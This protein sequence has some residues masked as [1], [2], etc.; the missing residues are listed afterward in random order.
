MLNQLQGVYSSLHKHQVK[1]ITIGGIAAILHGVPRA[2]FDLDL[3]IE[4]T[5]AN[6]QRLLE[7]LLEAG[8][9]TASLTTAPELLSHEVTVFRDR[10]QIDVQTKTPGITFEEVWERR[11]V[12]KYKEQE[13]YVL[14]RADLIASKR[15]AG[16]QKD[17]EDVQM[18]EVADE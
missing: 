10:V 6:A 2:T 18:L 11:V 5:P 14:S 9:G 17:L 12:M 15:A 8:L 1:Y 3:L 13:F 16:R 4:A 7:A